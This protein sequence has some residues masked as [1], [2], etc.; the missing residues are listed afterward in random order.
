VLKPRWGH[1]R[2]LFSEAIAAAPPA[3]REE[4]CQIVVE[5]VVVRDRQVEAITWTPPAP[6]FF[7]S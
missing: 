3:R 7:E 6:P 4:L 1:A 2:C 5:R